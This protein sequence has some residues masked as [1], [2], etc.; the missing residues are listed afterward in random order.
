M[1]IYVRHSF[2]LNT[3]IVCFNTLRKNWMYTKT[4]AIYNRIS[5]KEYLNFFCIIYIPCTDP[6]P[7]RP[8]DPRMRTTTTSTIC[9]SNYCQMKALSYLYSY[10]YR[11][12][13]LNKIYV[14]CYWSVRNI[15]KSQITF[16]YGHT[17]NWSCHAADLMNLTKSIGMT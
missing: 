1:S 15:W 11:L 12:V 6:D 13:K 4:T 3:K 10:N 14:S 8:L 17:Y 2:W 5:I 16:N 9:T 7:P